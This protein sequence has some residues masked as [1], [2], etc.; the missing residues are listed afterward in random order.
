MLIQIFENDRD[1]FQIAT[2]NI[3]LL[4]SVKYGFFTIYLK[5]KQKNWTVFLN[6]IFNEIQRKK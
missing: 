3:F 6:V 4:I 2:D 1:Y 5:K